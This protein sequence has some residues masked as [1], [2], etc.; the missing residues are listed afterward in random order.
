VHHIVQAFSLRL[1]YLSGE[2]Y[3]HSR[4]LRQKESGRPKLLALCHTPPVAPLVLL[5]G[6]SPHCD[7]CT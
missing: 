7:R 6:K 4:L 5:H 3:E 1:L 2:F